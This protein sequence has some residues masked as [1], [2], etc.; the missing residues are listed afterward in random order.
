MELS[1]DLC[2]QPPF[3]GPH[4][5]PFLLCNETETNVF[6]VLIS[7]FC[8]CLFGVWRTDS[9]SDQPRPRQSRPHSLSLLGPCRLP[10]S[11]SSAQKPQGTQQPQQVAWC[12][13]AEGICSGLLHHEWN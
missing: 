1:R 4:A 11:Y 12:P 3:L 13:S 8:H 6:A 9:N 10:C 7:L 2:P 5:P